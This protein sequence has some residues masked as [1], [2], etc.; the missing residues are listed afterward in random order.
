MCIDNF[1]HGK[2]IHEIFELLFEPWMNDSDKF[3]L[4][5]L[6]LSAN[7]KTLGDLDDALEKGLRNGYSI[8]DQISLCKEVSVYYN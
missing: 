2:A 5:K 3:E 4:I 1:R 6:Y 7:N 8:E